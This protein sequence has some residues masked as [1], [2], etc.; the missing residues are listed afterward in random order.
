MRTAPVTFTIE[1]TAPARWLV[2]EI[3]EGAIR[4]KYEIPAGGLERWLQ[5]IAQT[6]VEEKWIGPAAEQRGC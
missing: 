3:E 6:P 5:A 1:R 2:A 4:A